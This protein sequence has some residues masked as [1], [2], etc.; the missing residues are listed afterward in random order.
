VQENWGDVSPDLILAKYVIVIL[1]PAF[2]EDVVIG[3]EEL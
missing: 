3:S 2:H 1:R